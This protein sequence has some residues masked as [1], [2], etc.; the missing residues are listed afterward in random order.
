VN[1]KAHFNRINRFGNWLIDTNLTEYDEDSGEYTRIGFPIFSPSELRKI[2]SQNDG[3]YR[4]SESVKLAMP[5][6]WLLKC[7]E[8]ITENDFEWPKS[9][10]AEYFDR[11]ND[12]GVS[13]RIWIPTISYVFL[14]MLDL[15]IRKIQVTSLDSGEGDEEVFDRS[16]KKWIKNSSQR[17]NYWRSLG[18][19]LR[20]RGVVKNIHSATEN[21]TGFFINTNKTQ[22]RDTG[23]SETSGY[24]IPWYNIEL[25][26]LFYDLRQW[27][28]K[29]NP[30]S[31]PTAYRDIPI[32]VFQMTPSETVLAQIPDRFYL[33]RSPRSCDGKNPDCPPSDNQMR[34]YWNKLMG[35][36]ERRLKEEGHD[37]EIVLKRNP[38]TNQPE[39]TIFTPHGLRVA[40][41]TAL[42]ESGVPI[43]VL[44]KVVAGHSTILMTLYY[45]KMDP[46]HISDQLNQ[47][48][49]SIELGQQENLN[50]WLK[51]ASWEEAKKYV[52]S[53]DANTLADIGSNKIP[54]NIWINNNLGI[55]PYGG[56]RCHDGGEL[57]RKNTTKG[58]T[59]GPV[60]G[61]AKNCVRCRHL[62]T[63]TPWMIQLWLHS[64]KLLLKSQ[65]KAKEVDEVRRRLESLN[66][67][68]FQI[69]K[70]KG[71]ASISESLKAEIKG[72]ETNLE[73]KTEQLDSLLMDAHATYR[74]LESVRELPASIPSEDSA[75]EHTPALIAS[76]KP[77]ISF[78]EVHELRALDST[79]QAG[80]L[81]THLKDSDLERDRDH[82][83]D[84]IM[85][86]NGISP[87]SLSP[88]T[89]DEKSIASDAACRFLLTE[90]DD[91]EIEQLTSNRVT[92]RE[93]GIERK[94]IETVRLEGFEP[95]QNLIKKSAD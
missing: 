10:S 80:R 77:E 75:T 37:V 55:C 93:L 19:K 91:H 41:L 45:I 39:K 95:T 31:K 50:Q 18:N 84:Q 92:L 36:L 40:G 8:I 78:S 47:A 86:N 60:P 22:D 11:W 12:S 67:E 58:G 53:N 54:S 83:I 43:E 69:L 56:T 63:G 49:K 89:P 42:A 3:N 72:E 71:S 70:S 46:G 33:F 66:S 51:T 87:I 4:P 76:D 88:L 14:V 7:K 13:E 29:Y 94:V 6:A 26:D 65:R 90:L 30:V 32:Q 34:V 73:E 20:N 57:L 24:T 21:S 16:K 68:R 2:D 44:S 28:E 38:V 23:F 81:Y 9:I 35:E 82:F 15:P 5:T 79:V 85:F 62:I 52:T 1:Q 25:I 48:K 17:S 64:N 59:Y 74:L 61:G 27:Q